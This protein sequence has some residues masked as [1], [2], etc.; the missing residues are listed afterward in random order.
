MQNLEILR[1]DMQNLEISILACRI[2][3][4]QEINEWKQC[5]RSSH[6]NREGKQDELPFAKTSGTVTGNRGKRWPI[7]DRP[8]PSYNPRNKCGNTIWFPVADPYL[9]IREGPGHQDPEI[10]GTPGL[11][12]FF[13]PFGLQFGLTIR[14][15]AGPPG[16]SPESAT[17]Q[18]ISRFGLNGKT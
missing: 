2:L 15:R 8:F 14:G 6:Q 7:V 9:V 13:T 11:K 3:K 5:N 18:A 10:T 16:P 1:F 12:K 4:F 17:E